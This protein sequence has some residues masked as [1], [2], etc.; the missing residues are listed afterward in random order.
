MG[1]RTKS[2]MKKGKGKDTLGDEFK[3]TSSLALILRNLSFT[4]PK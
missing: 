1:E 3:K 4:R 2:I